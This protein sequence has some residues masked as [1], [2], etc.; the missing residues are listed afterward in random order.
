MQAHPQL[1]SALVAA[2]TRQ[3]LLEAS[4]RQQVSA[5]LLRAVLSPVL[6]PGRIGTAPQRR[7][8]VRRSAQARRQ[9][10]RL[11]HTSSDA[12]LA[13]SRA[14]AGR[15]APTRGRRRGRRPDDHC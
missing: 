8:R 4:R 3:R 14:G 6:A 1:L 7:L 9:P 5:A 15:S 13:A 10:S 12:P 11:V 2:E